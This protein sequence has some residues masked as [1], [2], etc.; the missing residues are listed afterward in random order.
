MEVDLEADLDFFPRRSKMYV[1]CIR[2]VLAWL[3]FSGRVV[4]ERSLVVHNWAGF[5]DTLV[6]TGDAD[7]VGRGKAAVR[8]WSRGDENHHCQEGNGKCEKFHDDRLIVE[9][10]ETEVSDSV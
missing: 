9:E 1:F 6:T 8:D 10:T 3:N 2:R 4:T 7:M 5:V